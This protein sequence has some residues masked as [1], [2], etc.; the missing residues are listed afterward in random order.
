MKSVSADSADSDHSDSRT[1]MTQSELDAWHP[2][3]PQENGEEPP[4]HVASENQ[5][6]ENQRAL[7]NREFR[8]QDNH[9]CRCDVCRRLK[10]EYEQCAQRMERIAEELRAHYAHGAHERALYSA[11][12][13]S[14]AAE[15]WDSGSYTMDGNCSNLSE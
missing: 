14:Y 8:V 10:E 5:S 1:T 15:F 12:R 6:D 13:E 11:A 7:P 4:T 9:R 3:S 2:E